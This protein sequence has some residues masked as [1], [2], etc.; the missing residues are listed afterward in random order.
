MPAATKHTSIRGPKP[1]A[2]TGAQEHFD[3][4]RRAIYKHV[5]SAYVLVVRGVRN[6]LHRIGQRADRI[7]RVVEDRLRK[8]IN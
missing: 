8:P 1:N 4:K 2:K 7:G 3:R 5:C 6:K